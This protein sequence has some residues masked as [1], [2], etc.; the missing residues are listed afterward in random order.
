[1]DMTIPRIVLLGLGTLIMGCSGKYHVAVNGFLDTK[2]VSTIVPDARVGILLDDDA[3]NP[4][5]R[6]EVSQKIETLLTTKGYRV[7][8]PDSADYQLSFQYG[9][10][11]GK[12]VHSTRLMHDPPDIVTIRRTNSKGGH[13]YSTIHV[14]G[15]TYYVSHS[16]T[17]FGGWL[18]LHLYETP[19]SEQASS[20]AKP[21]WI[22]EIVSS[23]TSSDLREA[24]NPMLIA[25]FDYFGKNTEKRIE[26][27][28]S[29]TD[30]RLKHLHSQ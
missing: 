8:P 11:A 23:S 26:N 21:V 14:P 9:M 1:M 28:I 13:S 29:K 7:S 2:R 4:I 25:A 18:V 12:T 10:D 20:E 15:S 16:E 6:N 5:F 22:G 17:V 30:P 19:K 27:T 3:D 24:I